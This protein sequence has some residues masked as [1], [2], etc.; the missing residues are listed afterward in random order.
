MSTNRSPQL[1]AILVLTR[2]LDVPLP[3]AQVG[4]IEDN[5]NRNELSKLSRWFTTKSGEEVTSLEGYVSRMKPEQKQIYYV[6][7]ETKMRALSSP[8]LEKLRKE[9]VEVIILQDPL[10][11]M[12]MQSLGKF[13]EKDIVDAAK[14]QQA[15][16]DEE[17]SFLDE[18]GRELQT[19]R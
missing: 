6:T 16:T 5:D 8:V 15:E 2:R 17:K 11:E 14:E 19:L 10:D 4:L 12:A 9:D 7:G 13:G 3:P 1:S 18:K